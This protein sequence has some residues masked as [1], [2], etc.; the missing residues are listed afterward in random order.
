MS[1][2]IRPGLPVDEFQAEYGHHDGQPSVVALD[3]ERDRLVV[4]LTAGERLQH[5]Q[6]VHVAL[7]PL[8]VVLRRVG[9]GVVDDDRS[10]A[11]GDRDVDGAVGGGVPDVGA[12]DQHDATDL[13]P[14]AA[15]HDLAQRQ[16]DSPLVGIAAQDDVK[17]LVIAERHNRAR[18]ELRAPGGDHARPPGVV[19]ADADPHVVVVRHDLRFGDVVAVE[20]SAAGFDIAETEVAVDHVEPALVHDDDELAVRARVRQAAREACDVEIA[21]ERHGTLLG[22]RRPRRMRLG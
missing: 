10:V 19:A 5:G 18:G 17:L 7:G 20:F 4:E 11:A 8:E 14:D 21:H 15:R 9:N 13:G 3:T 1:G 16:R 22:L 6:E 2:T 12:G